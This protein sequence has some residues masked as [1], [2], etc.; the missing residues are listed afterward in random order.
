MKTAE[1]VLHLQNTSQL[2]L[3]KE[4]IFYSQRLLS[5]DAEEF[6]IEEAASQP[7]GTSFHIKIFLSTNQQEELPGMKSAIHQ[8]FRYRKNKSGKQLKQTVR[9]GWRAL[10]LAILFLAILI[11]LII[12]VSKALPESGFS[13]T[14]REILIILGWVALWRPVDYLLY[15]WRIYRRDVKLF[16]KLEDCEVDFFYD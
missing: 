2:L 4:S 6:I 10:S 13:F 9:I 8:H 11:P 16:E 14:L 3:P 1:I 12:V 15:E 5:P 7:R